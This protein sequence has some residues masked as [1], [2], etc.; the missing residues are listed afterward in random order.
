MSAC[1]RFPALFFK[2]FWFSRIGYAW[3][4]VDGGNLVRNC[5]K[6]ESRFLSISAVWK[7]SRFRVEWLALIRLC[8]TFVWGAEDRYVLR[9]G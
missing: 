4:V 8:L 7:Y 6:C 5:K 3:G 1:G 2:F 9:R